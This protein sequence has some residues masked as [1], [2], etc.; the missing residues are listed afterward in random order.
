[1]TNRL[2]I[3]DAL[4]VLPTIAPNS[5]H[6]AITSPPYWGKRQYTD[7]DDEHGTGSLGLWVEQTACVFD[8]VRE[9]L[10]PDA[11]LWV[12]VGDTSVGSGGAGGDYNEGGSREQRARYRQG[13]PGARPKQSL[14]GAP[15]LL[16]QEMMSRGW[17]LRSRIVWAKQTT[18]GNPEVAR[19]DVRH[20]R[21]PKQRYEIV[22]MWAQN[23]TYVYNADAVGD[24][25]FA[26]SAG[27]V[28]FGPTATVE[29]GGF[30]AKAPYP[31]WLVE[32]ILKLSCTFAK[33]ETVIDP[34][35]GACTTAKV[36]A[37]FG[38]DTIS[39]DLD[40]ESIRAARARLTTVEVID[41]EE[42]T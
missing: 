12:V 21:R 14:A 28:W 40:R 8:Q 32:R 41:A 16:E 31:E 11:L 2:Y 18:K 5:A 9:I 38:L 22:Q 37:R 3:G 4:R 15:F 33:G 1:M 34:Y 20:V 19:E 7:S 39:V 30:T 42:R 23:M 17:V 6:C 27:D 10:V 24:I 26:S 25:G 36:A 35:A 13:D 29:R